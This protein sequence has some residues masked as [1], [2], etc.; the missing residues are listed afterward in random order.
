MNDVC[1]EQMHLW[2]ARE[3]VTKGVKNKLNIVFVTNFTA[4]SH[5]NCTGCS[6]ANIQET[7]EC[8]HKN[9]RQLDENDAKSIGKTLNKSFIMIKSCT[10]FVKRMEN[11]IDVAEVAGA[12]HTD[13]QI[14]N[15]VFG[16]ILKVNVL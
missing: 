4:E 10:M 16:L 2:R 6:N 15:K 14:T 3:I 11:F 12:P 1:I 8:L 13:A 7:L 9:Y 5:D